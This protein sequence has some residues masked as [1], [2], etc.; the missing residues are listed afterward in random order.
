MK[1]VVSPVNKVTF[2]SEIFKFFENERDGQVD[3]YTTNKMTKDRSYIYHVSFY[4]YDLNTGQAH[5]AHLGRF[6]LNREEDANLL[7]SNEEPAYIN[8]IIKI[9]NEAEQNPGKVFKQV[10]D[11]AFGER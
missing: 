3:V 7:F 6:K 11:V 2:S 5:K 10:L 1:T 4:W 8:G 9:L